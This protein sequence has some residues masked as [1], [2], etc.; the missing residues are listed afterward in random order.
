MHAANRKALS[1]IFVYP[2]YLRPTFAPVTTPPPRPTPGADDGPDDRYADE[3]I[4]HHARPWVGYFALMLSVAYI[5]LGVTVAVVPNKL[6]VAPVWRY[7]FAGVLVLYG[8]LRVLRV[9]RRYFR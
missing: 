9:W 5:G 6:P 8:I 2:N 7:V 3:R 4:N 1:G